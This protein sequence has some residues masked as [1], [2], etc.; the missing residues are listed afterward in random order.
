VVPASKYVPR[1]FFHL[2]ERAS[3][4]EDEDGTAFVDDASACEAGVRAA[5]DVLAGAVME[6][7]LPLDHVITVSDH[8]GRVILSLTLGASVNYPPQ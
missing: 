7:R 6:G 3:V 4:V 1:Y 5:R 8:E 2:N